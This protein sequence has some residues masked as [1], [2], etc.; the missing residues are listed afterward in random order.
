MERFVVALYDTAQAPRVGRIVA[1]TRHRFAM[2]D[3]DTEI[4]T[5]EW[6]LAPGSRS[7]STQQCDLRSLR[8]ATAAEAHTS[9]LI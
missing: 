5:V 9:G 7:A 3:R 4:A 8:L 6:A 2:H 1:V